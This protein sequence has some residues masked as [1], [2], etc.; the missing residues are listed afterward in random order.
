MN[1][2]VLSVMSGGV[3]AACKILLSKYSKLGCF[4]TKTDLRMRKGIIELHRFFIVKVSHN[5]RPIWCIDF[6]FIC[7]PVCVFLEALLT[8]IQN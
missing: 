2:A 6:A 5:E 7:S 1:D 8:E 3:T 4:F